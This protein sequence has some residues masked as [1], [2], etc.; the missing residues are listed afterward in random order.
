MDFGGNVAHGSDVSQSVERHRNIEV[1]F[2]LADQ[3]EHLQR[4]EPQIGEQLAGS[5]RLNRPPADA[6]Q[7]FDDVAFDGLG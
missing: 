5:G 6:L 4:V 2:E 1:I 7:N 3:L